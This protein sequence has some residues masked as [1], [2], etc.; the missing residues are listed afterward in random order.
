M[1]LQVLRNYPNATPNA[2]Q[3]VSCHLPLRE[4]RLQTKEKQAELLPSYITKFQILKY[5]TMRIF[6]HRQQNYENDSWIAKRAALTMRNEKLD[7]LNKIIGCRIPENT[8]TFLTAG[9]VAEVGIQ[10]A[11]LFLRAS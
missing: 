6:P 3:F 7:R 11:T 5:I 8:Q 2:L 4:R 1:R 9:S 10:R